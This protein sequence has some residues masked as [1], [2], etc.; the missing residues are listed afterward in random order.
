MLLGQHRLR[1]CCSL[2]CEDKVRPRLWLV[3]VLSDDVGKDFHPCVLVSC[4]VGVE[5]DGFAVGEADPETLLHE[6]VTLFFLGKRRFSSAALLRGCI[7]AHQRRLV[8]DQLA[9]FRK[10]DC[11]SRLSG[12]FMV[13]CE[14]GSIERKETTTPVL[15]DD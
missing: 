12:R 8:I 14:L 11:S 2:L 6:H 1:S 15:S 7:V 3:G 13:G 9:R 5:V 4:A 10:I